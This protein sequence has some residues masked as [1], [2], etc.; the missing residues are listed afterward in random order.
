[1]TYISYR[2][3][4]NQLGD[5]VF[6]GFWQ[7]DELIN[8]SLYDVDMLN[9]HAIN[10]R[11][12][13][14]IE[15][16]EDVINHIKSEHL[17]IIKNIKD[18]INKVKK[19][20]EYK[21]ELKKKIIE[22]D[23]TL[24]EWKETKQKGLEE[25]KKEREDWLKDMKPGFIYT[26]ES[27]PNNNMIEAGRLVEK[28]SKLIGINHG[29][30]F[31]YMA[32]LVLPYDDS[33][34]ED[35]K[36]LFNKHVTDDNVTYDNEEYIKH[37]HF[38]KF[39][40]EHDKLPSNWEA[41]A[42]GILASLLR[43]NFVSSLFK[44]AINKAIESKEKTFFYDRHG[45]SINKKYAA[46]SEDIK[47]QHQNQCY[48]S[49]GFIL[50]EAL[51]Y[52]KQKSIKKDDFFYKILNNWLPDGKIGRVEKCIRE[53][54]GYYPPWLEL[55]IRAIVE[56]EITNNEKSQQEYRG[57]RTWV[58]KQEELLELMKLDKEALES[59]DQKENTREKVRTKS[60]D[61]TILTKLL[62]SPIKRKSKNHNK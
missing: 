8:A 55:Q 26:R 57:L 1:M 49:A 6:K 30:K 23:E 2:D 58:L 29:I 42:E 53:E 25:K 56:L 43:Y 22:L 27:P 38:V 31:L 34:Y 51:N 54:L 28:A 35:Y 19:E 46:V 60:P 47:Y 32:K 40:R 9:E 11:Y 24:D 17:H 4:F 44:D 50:G 5:I 21:E 18:E 39:I 62:A 61:I 33:V 7:N 52:R 12:S 37:K 20:E 14:E 13:N 41:K 3:A 59:E 10:L 48:I 45:D 36:N 15:S 16:K